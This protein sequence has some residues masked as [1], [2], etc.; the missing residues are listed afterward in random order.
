MVR[1]T[2]AILSSSAGGGLEV[3]NLAML[4]ADVI[5]TAA[6]LGFSAGRLAV[7]HPV[8]FH[9]EAGD[10]AVKLDKAV[11][12]INRILK[13]DYLFGGAVTSGRTPSW[14][15]GAM[16]TGAA[17]AAVAPFALRHAEVSDAAAKELWTIASSTDVKVGYQGKGAYTGFV[18]DPV[19]HRGS[20]KSTARYTVT[21]PASDNRWVPPKYIYRDRDKKVL[22]DQTSL[23]WGLI[24]GMADIPTM[25]QQPFADKGQ[26]FGKLVG[27]TH[28]MIQAVYDAVANG[29]WCTPFE[30]AV[31]TQTTKL[32]S[33]FPC[34]MFMYA[35]GY[36]PSAIHLG[37]GESWVPFYPNDP[38]NAGYSPTVDEAIRSTN[39]RW[40]L[41]CRQHLNLGADIMLA[42]PRLVE[43]D[44]FERLKLLKPYLN[45][46]DDVARGANLILDAVT[47][48]LSEADRIANTLVTT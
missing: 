38:G 5:M 21:G 47:V 6:V 44:H 20:I 28:G 26:M 29:P 13:P 12:A 8:R 41:E 22:G 10:D 37:R 7:G 16:I 33:C 2:E 36:P 1:Q 43:K 17:G 11:S 4:D 24:G 25:K 23:P 14:Q 18:D 48:H 32:A 30:I 34:T 19:G 3:S 27:Y 15:E 35:A 40:H 42:R 31:G 46:K 9:S 39:T 45:E